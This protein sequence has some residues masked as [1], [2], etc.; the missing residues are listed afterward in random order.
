MK[1]APAQFHCNFPVFHFVK[2]FLQIFSNA[3][4]ALPS[5][6]FELVLK[7][8]FRMV[9]YFVDQQKFLLSS[10]LHLFWEIFALNSQTFHFIYPLLS[11]ILL[12]NQ[13]Q[14]V[15]EANRFFTYPLKQDVSLSSD[16]E[17]FLMGVAI[18]FILQWQSLAWLSHSH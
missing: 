6:E 14:Y 3:F 16:L 5:V 18:F 15:L 11:Q 10:W 9:L 1:L 17:V 4:Q 13:A 2:M 8:G 12:S 7:W